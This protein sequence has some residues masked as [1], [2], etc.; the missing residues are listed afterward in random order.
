MDADGR[1]QRRCR[2]HKNTLYTWPLPGCPYCN[3]E[4]ERRRH[5]R[6]LKR[7][8]KKRSWRGRRG[9]AV[10]N[11]DHALEVD[12]EMLRFPRSHLEQLRLV[13]VE[14]RAP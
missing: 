2:R 7:M 14:A 1:E 5:K 4:N 11:I 3:A 13:L 8:D 6:F 10:E 9:I 12:A